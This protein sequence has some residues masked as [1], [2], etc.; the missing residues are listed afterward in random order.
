MFKAFALSVF[1]SGRIVVSGLEWFAGGST[2]KVPHDRMID[3]VIS[4]Y[5]LCSSAFLSLCFDPLGLSGS[6]A[7]C[8][9]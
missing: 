4:P 7:L 8:H 6:A 3:T 9:R 2:D 5:V 1:E